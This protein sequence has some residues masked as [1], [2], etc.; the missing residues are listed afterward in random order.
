MIQETRRL[1]AIMFTDVVGYSR[2]M[3]E[4]QARALELLHAVR[5]I[6]PPLIS[7]WHGTLHKE[8]D[9]GTLSSFASA[10]DA[11]RCALAIQTAL[12][13]S[14]GVALRIGL[15]VGDVLIDGNDVHG[16]GVNTAARIEP[17]APPG[18]I[19]I[20]D[21]ALIQIR[22]K[23]ELPLRSIGQPMLKNIGSPIEIFISDPPYTDAS[24]VDETRSTTGLGALWP[25]LRQSRVLQWTVAYVALAFGVLQGVALLGD[26]FVMPPLLARSAAILLG[27]GVPAAAILAWF[28]GTPGRQ[29][30][31][32]REIALLGTLGVLAAL[33][34]GWEATHAPRLAPSSAG[35][36]RTTPTAAANSLV[37]LPFENLG[38]LPENVYLS[39]GLSD[40][41]R[42][43][44]SRVRGLQVVARSSS[45]AFRNGERDAVAIAAVLGVATVIEGTL[46]KDGSRLRIVVR[47]VDGIEGT[48]RWSQSYDRD[49]ASLLAVQQ[50][51][52]VAA[53]RAILPQLSAADLPGPRWQTSVNELMLL[54]RHYQQAAG[55][56]EDQD[57][58][59]ALYRQVLERDP[60]SAS[61][62][63]R[64]GRALLLRGQE[65]AAA[66]QHLRHALT[67]DPELA[68]GYATLGFLLWSQFRKG[69]SAL[70]A[71]AVELNP[72]DAESLHHYSEYLNLK[73]PTRVSPEYEQ[74]WSMLLRAR[75]LDPLSLWISADVAWRF[76]IVANVP[77]AQQEMAV[78]ERRFPDAAGRAA[79]GRIADAA[80]LLDE[81]IAWGLE[82]LR[83]EPGNATARAD[84]A[85][86]YARLGLTED[87]RRILPTPSLRVLYWEQRYEDIVAEMARHDLDE[88]DADALGLLALALQALERDAEVVPI[89]RGM[90]LPEIAL[91]EELRRWAALHHLT[92]LISALDATGETREAR[93]LA[94]WLEDTT[95]SGRIGW[96]AGHWRACAAAML[97]KQEAALANLEASA[98]S[99]N[100]AWLPLLRDSACYRRLRDTPRYRAAI[101]AAEARHAEV[102]ARLPLTLR[103]HDLDSP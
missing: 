72:N 101:Q 46:H 91:D 17:L 6:L 14:H 96:G 25:R 42:D 87:S 78:I 100:L 98:H 97:G 15:H 19:A 90:G 58:A 31:L 50:E 95:A 64:L 49:S 70:F 11:T 75:E 8:I 47:L 99:A 103:A 85:E 7:E 51:I 86:R 40:E 48:Q 1:A 76:A 38:G 35:N 69:S 16:D 29:R 65:V 39:E 52:A 22:G 83:L 37:V 71:R 26:L 41:L 12:H 61:A 81:A 45:I 3:A 5:A 30:M 34:I 57:R 44:L 93:R 62:H 88:A 32:R 27:W 4:D 23:I 53:A 33:T 28:H 73:Y 77:Q 80:G 66:E 24:R 18:G 68:E 55:R 13:A 67:L 89:L 36:S 59:I 20:S 79:L 82:V 21:A 94:L 9:D 74:G 43:Q 56:P 84:V 60:L 10:V 54:A 63:A 102:R 2:L 92:T